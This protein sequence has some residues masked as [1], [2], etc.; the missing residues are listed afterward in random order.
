M[1]LE[2]VKLAS[3]LIAKKTHLP[4]ELEVQSNSNQVLSMFKTSAWLHILCVDK[5]VFEQ[6]NSLL[7]FVC[8]DYIIQSF[9]EML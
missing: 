1:F 4:F 9:S 8:Y 5:R 7:S 6:S 3:L 2:R